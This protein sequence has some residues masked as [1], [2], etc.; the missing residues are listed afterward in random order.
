MQKKILAIY[1]SQSGQLKQ[2]TDNFCEPLINAGY[3]VEKV[4][5]SLKNDFAFPWTTKRFFSVMPD[6]VL[7]IPAELEPFQLKESSYDLIVLGYQPWFLS[8]SIPFNSIMQDATFKNVL[9]NAPVITITGVRNMWVNAFQK[10]KIMLKEAKAD[11]VGTVALY[12]RHLNLVSIFTI[13]HWMLTGRK[14][15]YL[16]FFPLP[17]VSD[18][19]ILNTK[20]FGKI[21]LPYLEKNE[22]NALQNEFIEAKA[23][24]PKYHL[25]FIESKAGIM[26]KLWAKF[27]SK[28]QD[29]NF[30]LAA[31]KY[32]LLIALFIA[33]PLVYIINVL[34]FK[35]FLSKHIRA[36]K[37]LLLKLN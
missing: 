18:E 32:Y 14:D 27:I 16:G 23:V 26:F 35:P 12:D 1:Y 10:I 34:I 9:K 15:R 8:P 37:Q 3:S 36:K 17:G 29:K 33:A 30:W 2:I 25:M 24:D 19:D 7:S 21:A 20:T 4:R 22:W 11:H 5:I 13:F 28:K 6:C 31:F